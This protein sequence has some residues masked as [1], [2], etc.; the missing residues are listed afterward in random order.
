[1]R[2][3]RATERY[4]WRS[5]TDT[6]CERQSSI[7]ARQGSRF[8]LWSGDRSWWR[9]P[10]AGHTSSDDREDRTAQVHDIRALHSHAVAA[11]RSPTL[12]SH[13]AQQRFWRVPLISRSLLFRCSDP[14]LP[15]F[16][17]RAQTRS[18]PRFLFV[19]SCFSPAPLETYRFLLDRLLSSSRSDEGK[20]LGDEN[21][22]VEIGAPDFSRVPTAA[23]STR[24]SEDDSTR[25]RTQ[26][27]NVQ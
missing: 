3:S 27:R 16:H 25:E 4:G 8:G 7:A 17:S 2:P 23:C 24:S 19:C 11:G 22:R 15:T 12:R 13:G 26:Y 21:S 5:I 18:G 1:M 14:V 20:K 9:Y 6:A 10:K